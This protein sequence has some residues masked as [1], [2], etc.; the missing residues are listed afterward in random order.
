MNWL[1]ALILGIVQGLAEYLPISSSGHLEIF[2][3]ILHLDLNGAD[4]L[5]FNVVLHVATVLSTIVVLW[6]E[7]VPRS[8]H[9][10]VMR[11]PPMYGK[12]CFRAYLSVSSG[13]V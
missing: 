7:F 2:R 13:Y 5:Q 3:T 9:S 12:F 11:T 6:R 8:L 1:D 10:D 4:A